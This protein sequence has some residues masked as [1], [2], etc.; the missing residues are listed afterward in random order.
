[1]AK[2]VECYSNLIC[3]GHK[4]STEKGDDATPGSFSEKLMIECSERIVKS[5]V[6]LKD[7]LKMYSEIFSIISCAIKQC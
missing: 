3:L 4:W 7:N 5:S 2:H 6:G 1:M